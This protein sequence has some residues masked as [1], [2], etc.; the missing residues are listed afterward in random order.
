MDIDIDPKVSR[1][2]LGCRLTYY[3]KGQVAIRHYAVLIN[4][5]FPFDLC[6][7]ENTLVGSFS[8]I[9]KYLRTFVQSSSLQPRTTS[10]LVP[11]PAPPRLM[12][13]L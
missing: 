2:E 6:N 10:S 5:P 8:V 7:Q 11:P 12:G 1:H 9:V 3:H 13:I 4:S